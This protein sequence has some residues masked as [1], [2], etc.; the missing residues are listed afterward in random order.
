MQFQIPITIPK[1]RPAITYKDP[2]LLTGSCFTEHIG[3]H[4]DQVKMKTLQNPNGI[5]FDPI[6]VCSSLISYMEQR[7]YQKEDLFPLNELW[8]SWDYH[9]RFSDPDPQRVLDKINQ[10]QQTAHQ[11]L[12]DASWLVIT[13]GSSFSYHL[14]ETG[15]TVANCHKA[16]APV[17]KKH[18]NTISE[19]VTAFD[20][21]LYRLFK[22]NP[23]LNILFT[24]SPVRH[25]RDGIVDNNRSKARLLEAVHHLV[26]KFDRLYYFPAYEL[27]VDVLRDYRFYDADLVHPN[28]AATQY[29]LEQFSAAH[30]EADTRQLMEQIRKI[31]IARNHKPFHSGS[32]QHA[33][34]LDKYLHEV[35]TLQRTHPYI[36]FSRELSYFAARP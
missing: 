11:Y 1:V 17:F 9:S 14:V 23:Q 27:L 31:V 32:Q 5:L 34:F 3:H 18:M 13:L 36:D 28:Y 10:S 12:K 30:M 4:L 22:F 29:V 19:I 15:K 26:D 21:M 16:P 2:L 7:V 6:S 25:I 24:I 8:H 20:G 33:K 35:E